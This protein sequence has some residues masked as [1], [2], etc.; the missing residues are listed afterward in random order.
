M[1]FEGTEWVHTTWGR[2]L[3]TVTEFQVLQKAGNLTSET[4]DSFSWTSFHDVTKLARKI[5]TYDTQPFR[6]LHTSANN[7][8]FQQR[9]TQF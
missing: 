2:N 6:V 8:C 1:V 4:A 3:N 7:E 9:D 5:Q